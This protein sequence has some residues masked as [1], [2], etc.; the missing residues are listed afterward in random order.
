MNKWI[1]RILRTIILTL[2]FCVIIVVGVDA[3]VGLTTEGQTF[4]IDQVPIIETDAVLV[5]GARVN[6]GGSPS[7]MLED[8]LYGALAVY[9]AGAANKILVSGDHGS[10]Y[11]NEVRSMKDWLVDRGVPEEDIFMD[12]AGFSTYESIYR[13]RDVFQV[14]SL[15]ISTQ[16]YHLHRAL[17]TAKGLGM[18]AWGVKSDRHVYPNMPK[19][20]A[21]EV[22]A[23]L[24]DF[25]YVHFLKPEPTFL[26]TPYPIQ[27]DGRSTDI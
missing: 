26:G 16:G 1:R 10:K 5:L 4:A 27:G 18:Q 9:Q 14:R 21:R 13:A 23:R 11:Y 15:V 3:W 19:Y 6:P 8:R 7:V 24:K 12:H 2:L 25:V 20:R 22:L 17:Y